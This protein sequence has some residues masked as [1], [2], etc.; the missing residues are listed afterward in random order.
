MWLALN[1]M[2]AL[3]KL[4]GIRI[5]RSWHFTL[6]THEYHQLDTPLLGPRFQ[7]GAFPR[8]TA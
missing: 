5:R 1:S 7:T 3:G 8:V 6:G 2:F 4:E